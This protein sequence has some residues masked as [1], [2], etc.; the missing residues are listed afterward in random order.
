[1]KK[2]KHDE[3]VEKKPS[4]LALTPIYY[5]FSPGIVEQIC[6]IIHKKYYTFICKKWNMLTVEECIYFSKDTNNTEILRYI[7]ENP[8]TSL[9][10]KCFIYSEILPFS[11]K[12]NSLPMFELIIYHL[13]KINTSTRLSKY[14]DF[15]NAIELAE[16]LQRTEMLKYLQ[17][18]NK[19][20]DTK[21]FPF[22]TYKKKQI[23]KKKLFR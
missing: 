23:V 13:Q 11:I 22:Q 3:V 10:D 17:N 20:Q 21:C 4:T 5:T 6:N 16:K 2:I 19:I 1:M 15:Y 8:L 12:I 9:S 7:I 14:S 18:I